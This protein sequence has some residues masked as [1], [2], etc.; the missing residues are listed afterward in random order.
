MFIQMIC[1]AIFCLNLYAQENMAGRNEDRIVYHA[2]QG[3]LKA[4]IIISAAKITVVDTIVVT[5]QAEVPEAMSVSMPNLVETLDTFSW[6]I[7]KIITHDKKLLDNSRVL[8]EKIIELEPIQAQTAAI[9]ALTFT[10]R[11]NDIDIVA[12]TEAQTI[13]IVDFM[14]IDEDT[15]VASRKGQVDVPFVM[16]I[17][18]YYI[19]AAVIFL[20][21][22]IALLIM[23]AR[24]K[25]REIIPVYACPHEIAVNRF[26]RLDN[27]MLL[28]DQ[29][30]KL[31]F[32]LTC[33]ILRYY[34]EDRFDLNAPDLTTEEFLAK[35]AGTGKLSEDQTAKLKG[36]MNQC[37]MVKFAKYAPS[38]DDANNALLLAEA[39]VEKTT[40]YDLKVEVTGKDL[41]VMFKRV[42]VVS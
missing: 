33:L 15:I 32:E 19:I 23:R 16:P 12:T 30:F 27:E 10:A 18:V 38:I 31:F 3:E 24:R 39:F 42:E 41:Y 35:A 4:T 25:A 21:I 28:H 6:G 36:F 8:Y 9:P 2:D 20:A 5:L 26:K 17:M 34:I 11:V 14:A 1:C 40:N 37:D 29:Q 7:V 22:V 13:E